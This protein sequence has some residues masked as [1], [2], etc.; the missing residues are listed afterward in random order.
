[1]FGKSTLKALKDDYRRASKYF[2]GRMRRIEKEL[3]RVEKSMK[4]GSDA[5][6]IYLHVDHLLY[7]AKMLDA[8]MKSYYERIEA[9]MR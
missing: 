3:A 9:R 8:E 2:D 7:R 1:M 4:E 5:D 6:V